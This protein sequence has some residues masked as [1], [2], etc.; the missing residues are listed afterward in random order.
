MI[1]LYSMKELDEMDS[2][3]LLKMLEEIANEPPWFVT[4]RSYHNIAQIQ[5]I[6]DKRRGFT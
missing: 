3:K 4:D 2:S 1:D 5:K 6:L